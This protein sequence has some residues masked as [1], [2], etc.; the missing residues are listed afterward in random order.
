MMRWLKGSSAATGR[1]IGFAFAGALITLNLIS[2]MFGQAPLDTLV[3]AITGTWGTAY[4]IGQV[5]FKATPLLLTGLAFHVALRSGLFNIGAEGQL[6]LASLVAAWVATKLPA[7]LAWPLV[8]IIVLAAAVLVGGAYSA[9]A[10]AMR[11]RLGVHEII[12]GI[13]LNRSADVFLPWALVVG[14]GATGLRTADIAPGAR[15]PGLDRWFDAFRGSAVSVAFP[16]VV[17]VTFGIYRWLD[18]SRAGREMRWVGLGAQACAAQ[19][20]NV[21]RRRIQAMFL[22]GALAGL[23][24]TGTV[25][26]YKGYYELGLGAGAGF[27]GIAVAMVGRS[28][29]VALVLSAL[30]F[31]TLA[32]AGL[33]INA[34]VPKEA[35]GVLEAVV[36]LLVAAATAQSSGK[37][38]RSK[39]PIDNREAEAGA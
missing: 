12:S 14:I 23:A 22:S 36:I 9:I 38:K 13:M 16:L 21:A 20:I 15:L 2:F 32:Q 17:I 28:N 19:G 1:R 11:A 37:T 7:S 10:G 26:G 6:A 4:G 35:M 18:R 31:G 33:A 3:G 29:P 24:V 34:Q 5:L 25:L 30:A 39:R 8:L 27:S